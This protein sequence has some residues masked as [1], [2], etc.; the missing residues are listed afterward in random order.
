MRASFYL[1]FLVLFSACGG[2]GS[3]GGT[4]VPPPP[5]PVDADPGGLWVGFVTYSDQTVEELVGITTSA[6]R[7]TLLS[8][9]AFG[10]DEPGQYI[11]MLAVDGTAA[12]GT[13]SAYAAPGTTWSNGAT[14]VDLNL[15]AT[16]AERS[17]MTGDWTTSSGESGSFELDYDSEFEK[18]SSL[19]LMQGVWYVYDD[20][21]NPELVL[22]VESGGAVTAQSSFGCQSVGQV[23]IIDSGSNVY[24]W[25]VVISDCPIAGDY[26]GL[27][28][29]GD[30]D[31]GEPGMSENNAVLVS[32]S[33]DL[34][35]LLLPLER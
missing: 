10:S 2:G 11:G 14:V 29:M 17:R 19:T 9:D 6:G 27:A 12:T 23:S 15:S 7:F 31:T 25:N 5:P 20:T 28:I 32:L 1:P 16:I 26:A 8:L 3:G 35:A 34:R 18:G 33:N 30:I 24:D 13:G 4:T 21:L 22:T